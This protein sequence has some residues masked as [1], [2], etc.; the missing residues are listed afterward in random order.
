LSLD[1]TP[2]NLLLQSIERAAHDKKNV[3]GADRL[4]LGLAAAL[5]KFERRLKLRL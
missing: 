2:R 3:P 4:T 5:L 1:Q